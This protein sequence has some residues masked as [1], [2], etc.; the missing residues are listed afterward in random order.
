MLWIEHI[1]AEPNLGRTEDLYDL[2]H[3]QKD[4]QTLRCPHWT[5]LTEEE[6]DLL[7]EGMLAIQNVE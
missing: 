5:P 4:V 1:P 2:V 3:F 7:T 6:V